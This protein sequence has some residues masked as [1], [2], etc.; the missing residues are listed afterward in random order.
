V[1]DK[2]ALVTTLNKAKKINRKVFVKNGFTLLAADSK[3]KITNL[4]A[5]V[6]V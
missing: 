2:T 3:G 6:S 4:T 5:D 1:F